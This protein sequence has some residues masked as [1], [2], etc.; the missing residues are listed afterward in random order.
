[1]VLAAYRTALSRGRGGDGS[2]DRRRLSARAVRRSAD[3]VAGRS[4]RI[5]RGQSRGAISAGGDRRR[6]AELSPHAARSLALS[7]RLID[8]HEALRLGLVDEALSPDA[9]LPRAMDLAA[10]MAAF[11]VDV[12]AARCYERRGRA[13]ATARRVAKS[14]FTSGLISLERHGAGTHALRVQQQAFAHG[15]SADLAAAAE[16]YRGDDRDSFGDGCGREEPGAVRTR[17][18]RALVSRTPRAAM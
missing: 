17:S 10:E 3:R 5:D 11:P 1:M 12:Y 18:T 14:Q 4:L 16:P 6:A 2:C 15:G 7:N 8:G 13:R 9:V